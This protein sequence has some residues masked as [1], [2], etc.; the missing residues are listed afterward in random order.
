VGDG[1]G[2]V[3]DDIGEVVGGHTVGRFPEDFIVEGGGIDGD[4]ATDEVVEGDGLV[5]EDFDADGV[6]VFMVKEGFGVRIG[7]GQGV[8]KA[9]SRSGIVLEIRVAVSKGLK[10]GRG[11]EGEVGE[12]VIDE[13]VGE[14]AVD[15]FALGLDD[16]RFV[17]G[18]AEPV[19]G[20]EDIGL[21]S[22]HEA[23]GVSIL[24][25]KQ[26]GT[27]LLSG[28]EEVIEGGAKAADVKE[29]GG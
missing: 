12:S 17:G 19:E 21:S 28:E 13:L 23:G 10:F 25:T 18:D 4:V 15:V 1:G 5:G 29:A 3:I 8:T 24:N 7:E 14:M 26:E 2:V 20:F 22:G 27:V 9:V 11:I 16:R 6:G